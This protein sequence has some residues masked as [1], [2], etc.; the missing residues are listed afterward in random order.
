MD[1]TDSKIIIIGYII[2]NLVALLMLWYSW[3]R[4]VTARALFFLL[5]VWAGFTNAATSLNTPQVYLEY[6]DFTF[7]P[8]YKNIIL[9]FFS[10]NIT[11][12][13]ICIAICQLMIGVSM[14]LKEEIFKLGCIGGILFLICITPLGVG[15]GAPVTLIWAVGLYFLHRKGAK[16]YWWSSFRK[17][18][19]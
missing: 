12:I 13:V 4:P 7:L 15:S 11:A 17:K 1:F 14:I 18:Q 3:K 16:N 19:P 6:A 9:G 10:R 5:F 8:F 2:S